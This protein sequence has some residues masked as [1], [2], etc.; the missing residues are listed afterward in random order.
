MSAI[1]GK[2]WRTD[3]ETA[4]CEKIDFSKIVNNCKDEFL[5][6]DDVRE[7]SVKLCLR[8]D[9]AKPP[10]EHIQ[11]AFPLFSGA[12]NQP[13]VP[14][15]EKFKASER[16]SAGSA[17]LRHSNYLVDGDKERNSFMADFAHNALDRSTEASLFTTH[18]NQSSGAYKMASH[19]RAEGYFALA[20]LILS[21]E[22]VQ[23]LNASGR[24][25]QTPLLHTYCSQED[26]F[27]MGGTQ[28]WNWFKDRVIDMKAKWKLM[29]KMA[30]VN[31]ES[32]FQM[33]LNRGG[34]SDNLP[35]VY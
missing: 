32:G 3:A 5:T 7:L 31:F 4:S 25:F 15:S 14:V 34:P 12:V 29:Q 11:S 28:L 13:N 33:H 9:T 10:L 27:I 30:F 6:L 19:A 26:D 8:M 22:R 17:I 18:P 23:W 16:F 1:S 2:K 21:Q 20:D 35:T 24:F